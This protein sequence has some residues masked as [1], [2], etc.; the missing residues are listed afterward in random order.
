MASPRWAFQPKDAVLSTEKFD[1]YTVATLVVVLGTQT[2][3]MP[4]VVVLLIQ[5]IMEASSEFDVDKYQSFHIKVVKRK[6]RRFR[7]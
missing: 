5:E 3:Y 7:R 4:E 6:S 1:I 2:H